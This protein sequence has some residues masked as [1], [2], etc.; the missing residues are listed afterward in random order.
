MQSDVRNA[1]TV[2]QPF[3]N[4]AQAEEARDRLTLNGG[5]GRY[6][7]ESFTILERG[8]GFELVI[9]TIE[10]HRDEIEHQLRSSG[11]TL[12]PPVSERERE[13]ADTVRPWLIFG[14]AAAVGAVLVSLLAPSRRRGPSRIFVPFRSKGQ[15]RKQSGQARSDRRWIDE[16]LAES[17]RDQARTVADGPYEGATRPQ[18]PGLR[19]HELGSGL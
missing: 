11:T 14:A 18:T 15:A 19:S 7:I 9:R 10:F 13:T 17:G 2:T 6:G 4:R 16:R 12:N 5:P 1:V 3:P 8:D